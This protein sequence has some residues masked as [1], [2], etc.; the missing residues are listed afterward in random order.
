MLRLRWRYVTMKVR[1]IDVQ[2]Y[3]ISFRE[4]FNHNTVQY[5]KTIYYFLVGLQKSKLECFLLNSYLR[6]QSRKNSSIHNNLSSTIAT[7]LSTIHH[8]DPSY[9]SIIQIH[10]TYRRLI[11]L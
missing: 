4:C 3:V 2:L 11:I 10:H 7:V 9:R 5:I 8:T 6:P 1:H